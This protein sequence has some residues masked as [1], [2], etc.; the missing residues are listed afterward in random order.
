MARHCVQDERRAR[1]K[2]LR[3]RVLI[4]LCGVCGNER[5]TCSISAALLEEL[6]RRAVEGLHQ[7]DTGGA[8][9]A[10][11]VLM[12]DDTIKMFC[13]SC[14]ARLRSTTLFHVATDVVR[15]TCK[16]GRRWQ[17][18]VSPLRT[19]LPGVHLHTLE[20]LCIE[21]RRNR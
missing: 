21:V 4:T 18:K 20:W 6:Q 5:C 3:G 16:C 12:A 10:R 2:R 17:V 7:D 9:A 1:M 13:P 14:G 19:P 15:R 11:G 8:G